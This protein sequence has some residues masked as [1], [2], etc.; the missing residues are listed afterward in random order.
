MVF[1]L[2]SDSGVSERQERQER[3]KNVKREREATRMINGRVKYL[4]GEFRSFV[5]IVGVNCVP[6]RIHMLRA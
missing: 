1:P 6:L 2:I 4:G 5:T 3:H